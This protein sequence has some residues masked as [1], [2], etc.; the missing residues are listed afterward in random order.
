MQPATPLEPD[1]SSLSASAPAP[2]DDATSLPASDRSASATDVSKGG[3]L[4]R[5]PVG[6]RRS[7]ILGPLARLLAAHRAR[8]LPPLFLLLV[9]QPAIVVLLG[10]RDLSS[11]H[12][13]AIGAAEAVPAL[14]IHA[15]RL[16]GALI[17]SLAALS[18][19]GWFTSTRR[20]RQRRTSSR[21][22]R[23]RPRR[24]RHLSRRSAS[25]R[26]AV[27][28]GSGEIGPAA[29]DAASTP[30]DAGMAT[31]S[32]RRRP[33]RTRRRVRPRATSAS[34][35]LPVHWLLAVALAFHFFCAIL[36]QF[37]GIDPQFHIGSLYVGLL[38]L[39]LYAGRRLAHRPVLEAAQWAIAAMM[40]ASLLVHQVM[41]DMTATGAA[42]D[43]RLPFLDTRFWG[44]GSGPN[45]IAPLAVVQLIL[46]LHLPARRSIFWIVGSLVS[47]LAAV[48]VILWSQSQTT[49]AVALLVLPLFALRKRFGTRI[50]D[51]SFEAHHVVF[52]LAVMIGALIFLGTELIRSGAWDALMA[53]VPGERSSIW[54]SGALDTATAI[55]DQMMTGRG[56][57]W[58]TAIDIWRDD[59]LLG[60]GAQAW[61]SEFR[62][63]YNL[64]YGVHAHNQWLQALSVSG[65]VGFVAL[66]AY[67]VAL[68][69]FAWKTSGLSRGFTLAL[70]VLV[71]MRM[72]TET[73]L[74]TAA[75]QS[76][77]VA[78]HLLLLY[79]LFAYGSRAERRSAPLPA[80]S[81]QHARRLP[82]TV[83]P[84]H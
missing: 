43:Q 21:R 13:A 48:I 59:P 22:G 65:L 34:A 39:A 55:G 51:T 45:S 16:G 70:F 15:G 60:F 49:W 42:L 32:R 38:I 9:L 20:G 29:V 63:Y 35:A 80:T 75:M 76:S 2:R 19:L 71:L 84:S 27:S 8:L 50:S 24:S 4:E 72:V 82:G 1:P 67:V 36:P 68:A 26:Q 14:A 11:F 37:I 17:L 83:L 33:S 81:R 69:W 28:A 47:A 74:D 25:F 6:L 41:P 53:M 54:K 66:T 40:V 18:C 52:G 5:L 10:G 30:V 57:I 64:P 7:P 46:Q 77:D 79:A 44:L 78:T 56:R 62:L 3:G 61:G 58:S 31:P 73:P 12:T 23:R